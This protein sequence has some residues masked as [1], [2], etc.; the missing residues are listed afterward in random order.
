MSL[1][2]TSL[3]LII[4][5]V[6]I[7]NLSPL[8]STCSA[9]IWS[10]C[11]VLISLIY[12]ARSNPLYFSHCYLLLFPRANLLYS[13]WTAPIWLLYSSLP[14]FLCFPSLCFNRLWSFPLTMSFPLCLFC[15]LYTHLRFLRSCY[16]LISPLFNDFLDQTRSAQRRSAQRV[17]VWRGLAHFYSALSFSPPELKYFSFKNNLPLG[18]IMP[19]SL[20]SATITYKLSIIS[21]QTWLLLLPLSL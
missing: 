18:S 3:F 13:I 1:H 12:F 16:Y 11:S 9:P 21:T 2:T 5:C 4:Y 6:C 19:S 15:L 14:L 20:A 17:S 10:P 8:I 7:Y